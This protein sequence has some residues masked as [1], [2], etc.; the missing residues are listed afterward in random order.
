MMKHGQLVQGYFA[1]F[2]GIKSLA[3]ADDAMRRISEDWVAKR[4]SDEDYG[5]LS[6]F[7]YE[8]RGVLRKVDT[9]GIRIPSIVQAALGRG[10][11]SMFPAKKRP[12]SPDK[13]AS[14]ERRGVLASTN[15]LPSQLHRKFTEAQRAVLKV[16]GDE[17]KRKGWC[18]LYVAEIA[19][20]AGCCMTT[21][22][23]A[24]HL[25]ASCFMLTVQERRR[26][27]RPHLSNTIRII[28]HEWRRW[29]A[30]PNFFAFPEIGNASIRRS[31]GGA[32]K[33]LGPTDKGL[34]DRGG[35]T[36]EHLS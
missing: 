26:N 2:M 14:R 7:I 29:I 15:P 18:Q 3:K 30:S 23:D 24:I 36:S 20:R 21:A 8:L 22:R 16:V 4:L 12:K 27:G 13:E 6:W 17:V 25:A 32:S 11:K 5:R 31:E 9:V 28:S 34:L 33:D 10:F 1:E 35:M 19:A